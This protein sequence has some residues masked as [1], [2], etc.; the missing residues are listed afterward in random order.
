MWYDCYAGK[1]LQ[2]QVIDGVVRAAPRCM[3]G[4]HG[5]AY[6]SVPQLALSVP[7]QGMGYVAITP[8]KQRLSLLDTHPNYAQIWLRTWVCVRQR[9]LGCAHVAWACSVQP[10]H[11]IDY[12][13][14]FGAVRAARTGPFGVDCSHPLCYHRLN[15]SMIVL[16]QQVVPI[17]LAVVDVQ[18]VNTSLIPATPNYTFKV[19]GIMVETDNDRPGVDFQYVVVPR[20]QTHA[21]FHIVVARYPWESYPTLHHNH[22]MA[23]SPF[24]IDTCDSSTMRRDGFMPADPTSLHHAGFLSR[25]RGSRRSSPAATMNLRYDSLCCGSQAA[26]MGHRDWNGQDNHNFLKDWTNTTT[27]GSNATYPPGWGNK[28]VTWVSFSDARAACHWAGGRLPHEW[29]WQYAAQGNTGH[30]YPWGQAFQPDCVP[31]QDTGRVLRG[32]DDVDAHPCGASPFGV[33]DVVSD[34]QAAS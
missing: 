34:V 17:S 12:I 13:N 5:V 23:I 11:A 22:T 4:N 14:P 27:P 19:S 15:A 32:P 31:V 24:Y 29:E 3:R 26:P 9:G 20:C 10:G 25:M 21:S 6:L 28:P 8:A 18:P 16:P 1:S 2:A 30:Q 7:I 33:L